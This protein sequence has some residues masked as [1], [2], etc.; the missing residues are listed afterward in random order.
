M[1]SPSWGLLPCGWLRQVLADGDSLNQM[2]IYCDRM[3]PASTSQLTGAGV[4]SA[5]GG[6]LQGSVSDWKVQHRLHQN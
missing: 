2:S 5:S 1:L 6:C 4:L 3:A